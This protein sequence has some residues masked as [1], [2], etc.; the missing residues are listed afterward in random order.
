MIRFGK[1]SIYFL[2]IIVLFL[3]VTAVP[4]SATATVP[5]EDTDLQDISKDT[6]D[7]IRDIDE[8]GGWGDGWFLKKEKDIRGGGA[9]GGLF[10]GLGALLDPSTYTDILSSFI[11]SEDALT[12][13]A[14]K[15]LMRQFS[16]DVLSWVQSGQFDGGPLFV[17][18]YG[19]YLNFAAT[20]ASDVFFDDF[21]DY[22]YDQIPDLFNRDVRILLEEARTEKEIPFS[23]RIQ[24]PI[25]DV[26]GFYSDFVGGLDA[27]NQA[28]QPGCNPIST[29]TY[30]LE[31]LRSREALAV[32]SAKEQQGNSGT[33]PQQECADTTSSGAC[34]RF[35]TLSPGAA[36]QEQLGGLLTSDTANFESIDE[37]N[38][39]ALV[40]LQQLF[41]ALGLGS[42]FFEDIQGGIVD[43]NSFLN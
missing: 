16:G 23:Q 37:V 11:P 20:N 25:A 3:L 40:V 9:G 14:A 12:Q 33:V 34:R 4:L 21:D 17:T 35:V 26:E 31:E 29:Y 39:L 24:C 5:V 43:I 2:G 38:E 30:S 13:L 1:S 22:A 41:G 32:E 10:G 15:Q 19:D 36:V 8:N 28:F 42:T 6:R 7:N 18:N 27:W